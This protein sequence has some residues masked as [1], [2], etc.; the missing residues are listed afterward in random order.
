MQASADVRALR[1]GGFG[2][3]T[4]A[5]V[6]LAFPVVAALLSVRGANQDWTTVSLF[7]SHGGVSPLA[8]VVVGIMG[9]AAVYVFPGLLWARAWARGRWRWPEELGAA[10]LLSVVLVGVVCTAIKLTGTG[11]TRLHLVCAV[12]GLDLVGLL[13]MRRA[14]VPPWRPKGNGL[15]IA[16]ILLFLMAPL[17][18]PLW[19][20]LVAENFTGD[21]LEAFGFAD[22]LISKLLPEWDLENGT[23]GFYPHF[24]SHAF[25]NVPSLLLLGRGEAGIRWPSFLYLGFAAVFTVALIDPT[26]RW[27]RCALVSALGVCLYALISMFNSTYDPYFADL[28]ELHGTDTL[29]LLLLLMSMRFLLVRHRALFLLAAFLASTCQ[30]SGPAAVLLFLIAS[31]VALEPAWRRWSIRTLLYFVLLLAAYR[32]LV[33]LGGIGHLSGETQFSIRSFA[34]AHIPRSLSML[35]VRAVARYLWYFTIWSG[36]LPLI[37]CVVARPH[38]RGSRMLALWSGAYLVLVLASPQKHLHYLSPVVLFPMIVTLRSWCSRRL[39]ERYIPAV[40]ALVLLLVGILCVPRFFSPNTAYRD[41]GARTCMVFDSE[42]R[43]VEEADMIY[44]VFGVPRSRSAERWGIG[45]H[46]WAYY[47]DL[48]SPADEVDWRKYDF[49]LTEGARPPDSLFVLVAPGRDSYFYAR[50]MDLVYEQSALGVPDN[51]GSPLL[52]LLDPVLQ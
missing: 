34:L 49:C 35:D 23:W 7:P 10:L 21:G 40:L 37:A 5:V 31:M 30:P 1:K 39:H 29:Y 17:L 6:C 15:S 52:H 44:G 14:A 51:P 2:F 46:A 9:L 42:R 25:F 27:R 38:E 24:M 43:A 47:S 22:S 18:P 20:K 11:L 45:K 50:S 33:A 28:A 41:F 4:A 19:D 32:G 13:L 16:L 48:Y 8:G 3:L 36:L 26:R 12:L